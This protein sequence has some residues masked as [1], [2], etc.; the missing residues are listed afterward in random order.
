L[1]LLLVDAD[2]GLRELVRTTFELVD[3][4]VTEAETVAAAESALEEMTLDVVVIGFHDAQDE[5][6][7]LVRRLKSGKSSRSMPVVALSADGEVAALAT[8]LGADAFVPKPFSPLQL[9]AVA[10][11][12]AGRSTAV[13]LLEAIPEGPDAQLLLYARDLRHLLE[14]ERGHR[15][16][17]RTSYREAVAALAAALETRSVGGRGHP[18]RVRRYALALTRIVEPDLASDPGLEL[19]FLLHDVGMVG[20]PDAIVRKPGALDADEWAVVR[21]HPQLGAQLLSA[22]SLLRGEGIAIVRSHHERWDGKGYPDGL[23]GTG[24]PLGARILALADTLDAMLTGRHY[25]P[26]L[27]WEEAVREIGREAGR[28]FDPGVVAAFHET[29]PKLRALGL[30][31]S[32]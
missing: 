29:G 10:E 6:A 11:R 14:L 26:A 1:H 28:Q 30:A 21:T 22:L 16:L 12:L 15:S 23:A 32:A 3:V 5:R 27:A 4:E 8:T 9:L 20:I 24:I 17:L 25:R 13:P 2:A 31:L 7:E 18:E 19:G